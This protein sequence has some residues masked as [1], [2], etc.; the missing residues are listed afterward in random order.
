MKQLKIYFVI[1]FVTLCIFE[2]FLQLINSDLFEKIKIGI[3]QKIRDSIASDNRTSFWWRD[4]FV[5]VMYPMHSEGTFVDGNIFTTHPHRGWTTKPNMKVKFRDKQYTTNNYGHRTTRKDYD[6]KH[7]N[8][9]L[10]G[11][12]FTFGTDAD[13][14]FNWA[15]ILQRELPQFNIINL[16]VAGYGIDQML[17]TLREEAETFPPALIIVSFETD[18]IFRA[19]LDFRDYKKP[20]FIREGKNLVLKN[21]PIGSVDQE[22]EH[23]RSKNE[24]MKLLFYS[25]IIKSAYNIISIKRINNTYW[26]LYE[27]I[28]DEFIKVAER[29]NAQIV[30]VY[31]PYGKEITSV[32]HVNE[33]DKFG[34]NYL[35]SDDGKYYYKISG[36][37][38][39]LLRYETTK[40]VRTVNFRRLFH[41]NMHR[42]FEQIGHYL[43]NESNFVAETLLKEIVIIMQGKIE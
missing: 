41:K 6:H 8:I 24:L 14:S 12:S 7:L 36:G 33:E 40:N 3:I 4:Y 1:I 19:T 29:Y 16:G 20:Y 23:I 32:E 30:F 42:N 2:M 31:F 38:K 25:K 39:I 17:L 13:D 28:F 22:I 26:P 35:A 18:D 37:E 43:K 5:R 15:N 27:N 10:I 34:I 21:V 9:L 11:D